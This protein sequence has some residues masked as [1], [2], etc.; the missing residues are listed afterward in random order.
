MVELKSLMNSMRQKASRLRAWASERNKTVLETWFCY[1]LVLKKV[2]L[3]LKVV[4][5]IC[6]MWA[7]LAAVYRLV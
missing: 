7:T 1:V 5:V 2:I 3:S 6:K 4:C